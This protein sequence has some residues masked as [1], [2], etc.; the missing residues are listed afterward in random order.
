VLGLSGVP[1]AAFSLGTFF[2]CLP[3]VAAYVASGSL[4]AEI[5][6]DGGE[7]NPLLLL[8]GIFATIGAITIAGNVAGD[9]LK[10]QGLDLDLQSEGEQAL[11]DFDSVDDI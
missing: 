5:A 8:V 10:A 1:W 9:A 2:G 11:F 6:V 7:I 4:G 3:A